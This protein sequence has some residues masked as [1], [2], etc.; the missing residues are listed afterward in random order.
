M[1]GEYEAIQSVYIS[2]VRIGTLGFNSIWE[3]KRE[4]YLFIVM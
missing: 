2:S 4:H 3:R 1:N